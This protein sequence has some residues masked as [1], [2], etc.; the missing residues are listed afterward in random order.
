M[1]I[2]CYPR[3]C[4]RRKYLKPKLQAPNLKQIRI[5]K[6][7]NTKRYDLEV[8]RSSSSAGANYIEANE[9]LSKKD[10]VMRIKICRK[11]AKESIFWLKLTEIKTPESEGKRK[12]LIE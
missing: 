4:R 10:F 2:H 5:A 7:Q 9:S 8:I 1:D 6:N 12:A 11:E 3:K